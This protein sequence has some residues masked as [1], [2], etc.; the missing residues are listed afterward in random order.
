M[1]RHRLRIA[2]R[3]GNIER[4]G[5]QLVL[6]VLLQQGGGPHGV[7]NRDGG[8]PT[9]TATTIRRRVVHGLDLVH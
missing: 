5:H 6:L 9:K 8:V 3:K 1:L 4:G 7:D 2:H